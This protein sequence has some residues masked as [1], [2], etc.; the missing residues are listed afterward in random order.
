M[1]YAALV[2]KQDKALLQGEPGCGKSTLALKFAW[3][4]HPSNG[5]HF[6]FDNGSTPFFVSRTPFVIPYYKLPSQIYA[7]WHIN[8]TYVG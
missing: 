1:L 3:Q 4:T 8:A 6:H 7:I 2:E 5:R